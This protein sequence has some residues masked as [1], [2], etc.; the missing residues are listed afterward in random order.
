MVTFHNLYLEI[1]RQISVCRWLPDAA[2]CEGND[3]LRFAGHR[4]A[5]S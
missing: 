1:F 3:K 5:F 4:A 2:Q